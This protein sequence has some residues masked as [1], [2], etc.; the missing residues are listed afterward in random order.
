MSQ[1]GEG[2]QERPSIVPCRPKVELVRVAPLAREKQRCTLTHACACSTIYLPSQFHPSSVKPG[3]GAVLVRS[4]R[5]VDLSRLGVELGPL[6]DL[7]STSRQ[8]PSSSGSSSSSALRLSVCSGWCLLRGADG[9]EADG[10]GRELVPPSRQPCV[11]WSS[12]RC[13][14]ARPCWKTQKGNGGCYAC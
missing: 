8:P 12:R 3:R 5:V 4:H 1:T 10:H 9:S 11:R 13:T 7:P 14:P 2:G 6:P